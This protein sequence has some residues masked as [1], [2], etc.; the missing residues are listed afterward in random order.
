MKLSG[1]G[2]EC[3]FEFAEPDMEGWMKTNIRVQVPAFEGGF[4]CTIQ[5]EEWDEFICVLRQLEASIGTDARAEWANME[6]N[7]AL[8]F[9]LH[10]SGALE[11][12]YKFS[13]QTLAS[14]PTLSGICRADQ[15]F[16]Q[17]LVRSSQQALEDVR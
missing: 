10:K 13:A 12:Q 8:R 6:G 5:I 17:G 7:V 2:L 4:G 16:L 1:Q 15:S 9:E 11:I 14:G 3:D